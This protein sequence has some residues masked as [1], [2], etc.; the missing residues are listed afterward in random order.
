MLPAEH[1]VAFLHRFVQY[2]RQRMAVQQ[3]V[4]E[5]PTAFLAHLQTV[6]ERMPASRAQHAWQRSLGGRSE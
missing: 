2:L 5:T 4:S 1:F 3:V 6:S